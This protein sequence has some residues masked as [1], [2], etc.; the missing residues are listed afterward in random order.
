MPA[1]ACHVRKPAAG[2]GMDLLC[3]TT[4]PSFPLPTGEQAQMSKR[5][6][7]NRLKLKKEKAVQAPEADNENS[8]LICAER[9]D[10]LRKKRLQQ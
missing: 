10:T 3:L 7:G 6:A 8:T 4:A 9:R 5:D 2:E 1:S